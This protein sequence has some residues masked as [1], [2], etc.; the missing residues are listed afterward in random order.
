MSL[1]NATRRASGSQSLTVPTRLLPHRVDLSRPVSKLSSIPPVLVTH[2]ARR[3]LYFVAAFRESAAVASG[4]GV[5]Q[6]ANLTH[7]S[8]SAQFFETF[9]ACD[10]E[11]QGAQ[12]A[13]LLQAFYVGEC[14]KW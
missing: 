10:P 1:D 6:G 7:F 9:P 14:N 12:R 2:F 5:P 4:P 11:R 13:S 3:H 8:L